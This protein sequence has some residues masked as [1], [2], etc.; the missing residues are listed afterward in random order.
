MIR[1]AALDAL[2]VNRLPDVVLLTTGWRGVPMLAAS[3]AAAN[4][5]EVVVRVAD[6]GRFPADAEERR[7]AFLVNEHALFSGVLATG[8]IPPR[9]NRRPRRRNRAG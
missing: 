8:G 4:E 9:P 6:V 5:L 1:P 3:Y 2:L 7:D